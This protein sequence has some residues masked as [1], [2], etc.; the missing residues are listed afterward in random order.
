MKYSGK[1]NNVLVVFHMVKDL[2]VMILFL[3]MFMDIE[4][5]A[6]T[7]ESFIVTGKTSIESGFN[8]YI[9]EPVSSLF[10]QTTYAG[11]LT[12]EITVREG[13]TMDVILKNVTYTNPLFSTQNRYFGDILFCG[14]DINNDG[15]LLSEETEVSFSD[16]S[17]PGVQSWDASQCFAPYPAEISGEITSDHKLTAH[18]KFWAN[19]S[20]YENGDFWHQIQFSES[21]TAYEYKRNVNKGEFGTIVLPFKP[22]TVSGIDKLYT[23]AGKQKDENGKVYSLVLQEV[24]TIDAGVPYIFI[25]NETEVSFTAFGDAERANIP[26]G[27]RYIYDS[28]KDIT[29]NCNEQYGLQG[30][31]FQVPTTS[32]GYWEHYMDEWYEDEWFTEYNVYIIERNRFT[33]A[34]SGSMINAYNAFVLLDYVPVFTGTLDETKTLLYSS[35]FNPIATTIGIAN[36]NKCIKK[37][38]FN[39]LGQKTSML[40]KGVNIINGRKVVLN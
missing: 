1:N 23:I 22:S 27:M 15:T 29:I 11:D 24:S 19:D 9:D 20:R 13:K 5:K 2:R 39:V 36:T 33:R 18:I 30:M 31:F 8:S 12:A 3:F 17:L 26:V 38:V 10:F 14:I 35:D 32:I 4:M 6:D 34:Q 28:E 40:L 25:P 37:A 16:G 21:L 7:I